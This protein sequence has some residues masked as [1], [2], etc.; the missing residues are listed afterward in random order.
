MDTEDPPGE[1]GRLLLSQLH[2]IQ[3]SDMAAGTDHAG[4][5][6]ANGTQLFLTDVVMDAVDAPFARAVDVRRTRQVIMRGV[7]LQIVAISLT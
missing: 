2:L 6:H 1:A 3:H 4:V 5:L 7:P